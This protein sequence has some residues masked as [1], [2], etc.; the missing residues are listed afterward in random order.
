MGKEIPELNYLLSEVTKK[1]GRTI[2]TSTD[3]ESLSVLIEYETGDLVSASTL[4]RL[5]GYVS[6][7]PVPRIHTLDILARYIGKR[8]FK[9][10]CDELQDSDLISSRFFSSEFIA[11]KELEVGSFVTIG[12]APNRLVKLQYIG[13]ET[14]EVVESHNSKLLKGDVF[15]VD[16]FYKGFPLYIPQI[17]RD[18]EYTPSFIAG[19][20]GG[21]TLISVSQT[22][23]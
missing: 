14:F 5:W 6:L 10:Y 23:Q 17:C 8:D 16:G 15:S 3:F 9:S 13:N 7:N 1:Y 20:D 4:K 2:A 19:K 22:S 11:A 21:L 18:G 12:W